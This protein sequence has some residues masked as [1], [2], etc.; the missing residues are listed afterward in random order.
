MNAIQNLDY[1]SKL[2]NEDYYLE[3]GEPAGIWAGSGCKLLGLKGIVV[4]SDYLNVMKGYSPDGKEKLC[5]NAGENHKIGWDLTFSFPKSVSVAWARADHDLRDAIQKAQEQA[6][7]AAIDLLESNAAITR[8]GDGGALREST[9]GLVAALF[10]HCTSRS[11]DVQ[12]HTHCL[13]A[14]VSPRSDGS[15]GT[16]E[17]RDLYLWQ[18][19]A[20]AIYR[21]EL[22]AKLRELNFE[23]TQ[24]KDSFKLE[25][26]PQ[27]LCD[28]YSKR[29]QVIRKELAARGNIKSASKSGDLVT[30]ATRTKKETIDR[31]TLIK[32]PC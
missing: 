20:G 32:F 22:A 2:A 31:K 10:E 30:L 13:I 11:K 5:A 7:K 24:D 29:S 12:I 4:E 9:V 26:I 6:V 21:A 27:K 16:I 15:W 25:G 17:S 1:Y 14:N 28:F 3:S 18:K 19:A 23:I 8:R